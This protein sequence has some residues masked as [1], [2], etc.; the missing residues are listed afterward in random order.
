MTTK[1]ARPEIRKPRNFNLKKLKESQAAVLRLIEE[2][3]E[4]VKEMAK[5]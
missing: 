1:N 4:W 5:K 2:N 3:H